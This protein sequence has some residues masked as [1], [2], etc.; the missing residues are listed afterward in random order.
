MEVEP[1][2]PW[3][4]SPAYSM[5]SRSCESR[6]CNAIMGQCVREGSHATRLPSDFIFL[7]IKRALL[8]RAPHVVRPRITSSAANVLG[9]HLESVGIGYQLTAAKFAP[10]DLIHCPAD[11][12]GLIDPDHSRRPKTVVG[13]LKTKIG[14]GGAGCNGEPARPTP[15]LGTLFCRAGSSA[16]QGRHEAP[17]EHPP[18]S[19]RPLSGGANIRATPLQTD[20]QGPA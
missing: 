6:G 2:V 14:P 3:R 16:P 15:T 18:R 1:E 13:T 11:K 9:R 4:G 19:L 20:G 10:A 17:G 7:A 12:R 8:T 5:S